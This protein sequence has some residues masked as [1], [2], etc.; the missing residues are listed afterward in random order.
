M[1]NT[2][3]FVIPPKY[4]C[5]TFLLISCQYIKLIE[6]GESNRIGEGEDRRGEERCVEIGGG[7]EA[8]AE[9]RRVKDRRGGQKEAE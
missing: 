2:N 9:K 5:N 7:G 6:E 4:W 8:V 1:K 3:K